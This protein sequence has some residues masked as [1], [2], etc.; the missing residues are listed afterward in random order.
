MMMRTLETAALAA[1][2]LLLVG[3]PKSPQVTSDYN[4][5]TSAGTA[6]WTTYAWMPHPTGEDKRM[7]PV[8]AGR[9][10][11]AVEKA[12]NDR[13]YRQAFGQAPDFLVGYHAAARS[14]V[15][16]QTVNTYYGQGYGKGGGYPTG[17]QTHTREYDQGTLILDVY[18][19]K[20]KELVWRGHAQAEMGKQDSAEKRRERLNMV[21]KEM[22]SGFPPSYE[23]A[24]N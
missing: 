6:D 2:A 8:I 10:K 3:C 13:G 24:G 23:P 22:L 9:I 21:L 14:R 1:L 7:D 17:V 20:T 5:R 12:L 11:L 15:T 19:A 16:S 4:P 18:D